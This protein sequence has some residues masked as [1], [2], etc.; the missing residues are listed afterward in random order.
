MIVAAISADSDDAIARV[1]SS[2]PWADVATVEELGAFRLVEFGS[3]VDFSRKSLLRPIGQPGEMAFAE[4]ILLWSATVGDVR[5]LI[6]TG[7]GGAY[8]EVALA[9][10]QFGPWNQ[11]EAFPAR[12][13][14]GVL[15]RLCE[16]GCTQNLL[17]FGR[18]SETQLGNPVR[19]ELSVV[20]QNQP[21]KDFVVLVAHKSAE[22][23]EE[24][25][26][27]MPAVFGEADSFSTRRPMAQ[28]FDLGAIEVVG[29][30]LVLH[31]TEKL[32]GAADGLY[33]SP[34]LTWDQ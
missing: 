29:S 6:E 4:G 2:S 21:S 22:L 9:V 3:N 13:V 12:S 26:T 15:E 30:L 7:P 34:M 31:L 16:T 25:A 20:V 17:D 19:F 1:L 27:R 28:D 14:D 11:I 32:D 5:A 10:D 23:A 8:D 33:L 18:A 24:N